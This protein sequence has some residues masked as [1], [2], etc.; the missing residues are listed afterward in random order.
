MPTIAIG[1]KVVVVKLK[2]LLATFRVD[3]AIEVG[4]TTQYFIAD[5]D[6]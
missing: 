2:H 4:V 5:T 3:Y 1:F 6:W